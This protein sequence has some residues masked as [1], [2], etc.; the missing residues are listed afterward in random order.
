MMAVQGLYSMVAQLWLFPL[1]VRRLGTLKTFRIVIAIWPLLDF[2][3]PYLVLLPTKLQIPAVYVCLIVKIT[4]H[5]IA[6][7]SMAILLTNSVPSKLVLGTVNGV[8]ASVACLSRAFGPTITGLV[9]SVGLRTGWGGLAWWACGLVCAIG[10][11]ESLWM[12]EPE[13]CIV[14]PAKEDETTTCEPLLHST[15]VEITDDEMAAFA[16]Q[17]RGSTDSVMS[18][19][20]SMTKS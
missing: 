18:L 6:F 12:E 7:P 13:G 5:V 3:V 11:V 8:A 14:T 10:A 20:L 4:L 19:D 16:G 1:A 15:S 17:R 9:H 2:A